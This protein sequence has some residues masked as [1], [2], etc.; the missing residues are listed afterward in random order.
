MTPR[1]GTVAVVVV[2]VVGSFSRPLGTV[3]AVRGGVGGGVGGGVRRDVRGY[4]RRG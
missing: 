1:R 3:V 2:A 4:M